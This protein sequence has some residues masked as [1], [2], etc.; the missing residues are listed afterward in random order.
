MF[1]PEGP[2]HVAKEA[3]ESNKIHLPLSCSVDS[4]TYVFYFLFFESNASA[5]ETTVFSPVQQIL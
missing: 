5:E 2:W 1:E 3:T 4:I